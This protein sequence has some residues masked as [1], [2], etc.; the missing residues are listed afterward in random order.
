M[1]GKHRD[2]DKG[3]HVGNPRQPNKDGMYPH[4]D[5]KRDTPQKNQT[6]DRGGSGRH[7]RKNK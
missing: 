5:R 2:D 4:G 3:R 6:E 1:A 7:D